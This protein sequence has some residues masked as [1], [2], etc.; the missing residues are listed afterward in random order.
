MNGYCY[1]GSDKKRD[2]WASHLLEQC[3]HRNM[4][5][6][7]SAS[8]CKKEKRGLFS[9]PS[10]IPP[11]E[12]N[13]FVSIY[14]KSYCQHVRNW[15]CRRNNSGRTTTILRHWIQPPGLIWI[16]GSRTSLDLSLTSPFLSRQPGRWT[17][18]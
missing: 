10:K 6:N 8:I 17:V 5:V 11:A 13:A 3:Y 12:A 14:P 4:F 1:E 16:N 15:I 7:G 9:Y 18:F 2:Y